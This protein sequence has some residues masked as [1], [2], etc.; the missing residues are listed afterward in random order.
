[1]MRVPGDIMFK[2]I[3][4]SVFL[5]LPSLLHAADGNRYAYLDE[6]DP[7][8]P[9]LKFPKLITPQWVGEEGVEAVVILAID[10]MRGH[11]KWEVY[12]RP[13]LERLKRIDGRAPVSI[14]TCSIDPKSP[15]LQTW[16]KEGLS[17]E[18]HTFDHPCPLL[19]DGDFKKAKATY[20]KAIDLLA[21][22]PNNRPVAFR[23]PC[24]D[25][26]NT[27]SPRFYAEIFTD[28]TPAGNFLAIDSSVMHFFTSDDPALPRSLVQD[29]D[30]S[31]KFL[32]Y[33]PRDRQFVNTIENY[34]YPYVINRVC[35]Q[36]PCMAPSDWSAQ[37]LH[38]PANPITVADWKA[39]LDATVIKQGTMSLV[40]HPYQWVKPEQVVELIDHAVTK[41]GKKVKFLTFKEAL[42]RLNKN[43]LAGQTLRDEKGLDNGV[44]LLDLNGDGLLDL[45]IGNKEVKQTRIWRGKDNIW[46]ATT[47][48]INMP[49][50]LLGHTSVTFGAEKD[51]I[52]LML[53]R[54]PEGVSLWKFVDG[55]WQGAINAAPSPSRLLDLDGNGDLI[56]F[57]SIGRKMTSLGVQHLS[58]EFS[59]ATEMARREFDTGYRFVDL[60]DDGALDVVISNE[61]GFAIHL[62]DSQV[63][64]WRMIRSGKRGDK[65]ELPPIALHGRNMGA[66]F[67][68]RALW[69]QNENTNL[70]K[71][72]VDRRTFNELLG[73]EMPAAKEPAQALNT[74]KAR[75]GFKVELTAAE[76]LVQDPI[77]FAWGAD[78]TLWVVEMGDYPLGTDGKGK[79]GGKVKALRDTDGDGRYDKATTFLD[80]LGYPTGVLPWRKGVLVVCAPEI[81]YAEDR[82][83]DG[84]ADH[85]EPILTGFIEG[86]QQHRVNGLVWGLDNWIYCANG[87]SGG[88]VLSVKTGKSVDIRGRDFRFRP[89]T[90]ELETQ[91]GQ[92][93]FGRNRDDWGNW[94]GGNN[95]NPMWHFVLDD[96]YQRRNPH[97]ASPDP[98]QAV[99]VAPGVAPVYPLSRTVERF[100]DFHTANRF[101][102]ACSPIVY[103][104]DLFGPHYANNTFVSEPVHNL[105]HREIM[106]PAGT[107]FMS[108]RASDEQQ[109]EFLASSDNWFRPTMIQTGPDG[110]LWIADMYRHVIEH[111]QWI[112][113]SWQKK[114]DLRAGHDRG[115]LYRVYPVHV[116]P[117]LIRRL[118]KLDTAGLVAAL[119]SPSGWQRDTAQMLLLQRNEKGAAPALGKLVTDSKHLIA[120]VHALWTLEG[121]GTLTPDLVRQALADPHPGVRRH[122]VRLCEGRFPQT[123]DRLLDLVPDNDP[124]V[125]LQLIY[126][127][128]EWDDPRAGAALGK[129]ALIVAE[130]R[131][132]TAALL[133][134]LNG[135]N[136]EAVLPVVLAGKPQPRLVESLLRMATAT[137]NSRALVTLLHVVATPG[138]GYAPWQVNTLVGLLDMLEQRNSSLSALGEQSPEV[139]QALQKL[140]ALFDQA[141]QWAKEPEKLTVEQR[142]AL[143]LLGR[144]LSKQDEDITLLA[145]LLTPRVPDELQSIVIGNLGRTRVQHVPELL[146]SRWKGLTP[147]LRTQ[148]LDTLLARAEWTPP[149]LEAIEKQTVLA[150]EIDAA[151]RQRLL[152]HRTETIR[153]RAERLL[154]GGG[155][156][157][158]EAALERYR[159]AL[160]LAGNADHGRQVFTRVCSAC[161][162]VGDIGQ[163]VA[164]DL[165][166]LTDR[167]PD[168]LLTNILDPN[169]A[170]EARYLSY[171]AVTKNGVLRT[172]FL[173]SETG[174]SITLVGADGKPQTI[175]RADLEELSSTGKSA[176]PEGLEKD[177]APQDM[178]D[179]LTYL[180]STL[181]PPKRREFPNNKPEV[182]RLESD[183][184]YWLLANKAEIYG[185]SL[186]LEDKYGNLGY[187]NK[188]EDHAVWSLNVAK[189][190]RYEVWLDWAC[191]DDTAGN[192]FVIQV[193]AQ[194]LTGT[195][196]TTGNWD[197][198]RRA[199][200][201]T[202]QLDAGRQQLSMRSL[203]RI[204]GS[205][206]DLRAIRLVPGGM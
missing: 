59:P 61:N 60:N 122:A 149:L 2:L 168:Y 119:D 176:M 154:A 6:V 50:S 129:L 114:L 87:D 68:S 135:R 204:K 22:V 45:V 77:A 5:L 8:Y 199:K 117:R 185:S 32:K 145:G 33:K 147:A 66:F 164:P 146:L 148:V 11:E 174:T 65:G 130:D 67:H 51:G 194:R 84:K 78:G 10:D 71:D 182:I 141:R 19:K 7:Y 9:N 187:W 190:G 152:E 191:A 43:L 73:E 3:C 181:P 123:G 136:L 132:L 4:S 72:H 95:S 96:H 94:F 202:L 57:R 186:I 111:P 16:L 31:E 177:L 42:E 105:V 88:R 53:R 109:S 189:P 206:I 54:E 44:R 120:R 153:A 170:V 48:P 138:D 15:H 40:F 158:R 112:P 56:E 126:T 162:K 25:S 52:P 106:T 205:L 166:A 27:P 12:L 137:N 37:H 70:L 183:G 18:T 91:S 128:G 159:P 85:R 81:F 47:F 39:A 116:Q 184:G 102:S 90:G 178:A 110:A 127:L 150:T 131:W 172:G 113:E 198:Y 161:H 140:D 192:S 1:M 169:R 93:Q 201:G 118:D 156:K 76:P 46:K 167:S 38:K 200:V 41:H 69:W 75:P 62:R 180:R 23:T 24:C 20:E 83:G 80:N 121:L 108:R 55:D 34:P 115:R 155:A 79:S 21:A 104:D 163:G 196:T 13:I 151:R 17:L 193:G 30:G 98:R 29:A 49:T 171:V 97:V 92:T 89:D 64:G 86:N 82:D 14:M 143:R 165:G 28:R 173:T 134:S 63:K 107:T 101:T 100:N 125:R 160:A 133:S 103:R 195:V 74:I 142:Q 175:L 26:L 188:E 58:W 157:D 179:L 99:S 144:G 35:W 139:Q 124:H 36:F 197:T 203:G